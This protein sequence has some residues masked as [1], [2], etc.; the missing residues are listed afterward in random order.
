MSKR[1]LLV[2]ADI[3]VA[4]QV[5]EMLDSMGHDV[6]MEKSGEDALNIFGKDAAGFDLVITEL[7]MPDISGFL[8]IEKLLKIRSN[9]PIILLASPEGQAQ[10]VARES[11]IRWFGIKPLSI[12]D[13]ARTVETVFMA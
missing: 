5:K 10:S 11:G 13:L 3:E 6:R 9:M 2:D 1:I 8:L 4:K 7:G 12:A